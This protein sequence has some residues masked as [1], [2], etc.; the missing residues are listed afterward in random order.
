MHVIYIYTYNFIAKVSSTLG[1]CVCVYKTRA[2]V[3]FIYLVALAI[4]ST[5]FLF[6]SFCV[7]FRKLL[8]TIMMIIIIVLSVL[9]ATRKSIAPEFD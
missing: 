6:H 2:G 4:Y 7:C 9:F 8:M 1:V 5:R 3:G